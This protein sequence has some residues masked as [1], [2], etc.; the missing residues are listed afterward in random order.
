MT[1]SSSKHS[2]WKLSALLC[3]LSSPNLALLLKRISEQE[4]HKILGSLL[5]WMGSIALLLLIPV[6]FRIR[7]RNYLLFCSILLIIIP[8]VILNVVINA[9]FPNHWILLTT[10]YNANDALEFISMYSWWLLVIPAILIGYYV[11]VRK[12]IEPDFRINSHGIRL[13]LISFVI[14]ILAKDLIFEKK[15]D[16]LMKVAKERANLTFP[17]GTIIDVF[18]LSSEISLIAERK[19]LLKDFSFNARQE[20]GNPNPEEIYILFIGETARYD[21][22]SANGYS[23]VTDPN[24]SKEQNLI[25]FSD[26]SAVASTTVKAMPLILTDATA[27]SFSQSY[28]RRSFLQVYKEAGFKVY[29]LSNLHRFGNHD[30]NT[31]VYADEADTCI[32]ND[33]IEKG[34]DYKL[35]QSLLPIL[36]EVLKEESRKK[37]IVMHT[38]G[39]HYIYS[40]RYPKEFDLYKPSGFDRERPVS[41]R[42]YKTELINS[43]DN[44][45]LYTDHILSECLSRLKRNESAASWLLYF[46]DHGENLY[47]DK[48][49]LHLHG[50]TNYYDL[51][52]PMFFWRNEVYDT[53]YTEEIAALTINASSRIS[54]DALFHSIPA[55]AR[56]DFD[57]RINS[58]NMASKDYK[59]HS[60]FAISMEDKLINYDYLLSQRRGQ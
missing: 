37:L 23:R 4:Y 12:W 45:I 18:E 16:H 9:Q 21:N 33:A 30:T 56:I 54:L 10:Y 48:K 31:S 55:L 8:G 28:H 38:L 25:S 46:S 27:K 29:W 15:N 43:Y 6:F 34:E 22:W 57:S 13:G 1:K 41:S 59:V 52:I 24:L 36:D 2:I 40:R 11:L 53:C 51:H 39:S 26:V 7:L 44:S 14:L 20:G 42:Q 58:L 32:Y 19:E 47:D 35:D 3:V 50:I 60:R 49:N 5:L 17:L